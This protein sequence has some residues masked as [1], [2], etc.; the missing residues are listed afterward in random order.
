M[1]S[2]HGLSSENYNAHLLMYYK[3]LIVDLSELHMN[4]MEVFDRWFFGLGRRHVKYYCNKRIKQPLCLLILAFCRKT[5]CY[6][7]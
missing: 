1:H 7:L 3:P 5:I 6:M 4:G 2:L